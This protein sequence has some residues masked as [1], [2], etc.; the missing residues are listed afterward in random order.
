MAAQSYWD[1]DP[2]CML[3]CIQ[4]ILVYYQNHLISFCP[5]RFLS[6]RLLWQYSHFA[7]PVW[8]S[9][10]GEISQQNAAKVI[11]SPFPPI[12][13]AIIV[14][15][16]VSAAKILSLLLAS[17]V[18]FSVRGHLSSSLLEVFNGFGGFSFRFRLC[19]PWRYPSLQLHW[20]SAHPARALWEVS[21]V[22]PNK[23]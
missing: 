4:A 19:K 3:C 6:K 11:D 5:M 7:A 14:L 2:I 10:C 22:W 12:F 8:N 1:I 16:L 13:L 17:V 18:C 21:H 23:R 15:A 9:P 20:S